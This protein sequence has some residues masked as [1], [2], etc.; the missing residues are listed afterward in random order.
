MTSLSSFR[1][2][3]K[4]VD[5]QEIDA[6]VYLPSTKQ[7]RPSPAPILIDIHGGAFM[8]GSSK[9]VNRDQ[10]QDCLHRG[11][12][13]VAPNHRLCPQVTLL[14]GPMQDCRDLLTWIYKGGLEQFI[15]IEHQQLQ[16]DL[17]H[18]FAF[19]TSSGGT[20]ALSLGFGIPRPVAGI[21]SMYGPCKFKDD[22]WT[23]Q[24]AHI[25][26]K[27]PSNLDKE[28]LGRVFSESPI[29]ITSGV[30]LEGQTPGPPDFTDP[31][32]AYALTRIAKGQVLQA[33]IPDGQYDQVDP[34]RNISNTFPP[35][36]IVHGTADTM[37]P[38]HLSRALFDELRKHDVQCGMIEVPDE[39][40]TF[41]AKMQIGSETWNLQRQGFDFLQSL[42]RRTHVEMV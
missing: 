14:G 32:Q 29:P 9:M 19:G 6:D 27:L 42:I 30:S 16:L 39:E 26:A 10:I 23:T 4:V 24:L 17:D 11:W 1:V 2:V 37:V 33:I 41:A 13:V 20:L 21:L 36:F 7:K 22:F 40:H 25:A 38:I 5:E 15:S 18:V 34:V 35:V 28:F 8:L 31:R 12:V 3:Y